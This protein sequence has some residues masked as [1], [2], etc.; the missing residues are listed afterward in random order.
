MR[1]NRGKAIRKHLRFYR[2]VYGLE[3]PYHVIL[4]GNFI[5]AALKYKIDIADRL[6]VQLQVPGGD[7]VRLYITKSSLEE[8][9]AVPG[10]KGAN[11]VAWASKMCE[12]LDDTNCK[13]V[14]NDAPSSRLIE[15][16]W[17]V[18][19]AWV[20]GP[21]KSKLSQ[22]SGAEGAKKTDDNDLATRR[23][24][25]ATQDQGLRRALATI[26]GV[27][28][29]YLNNVALVVE[30][31]SDVS[32]SFNAALEN[33]K[34]SA[35]TDVESALLESVAKKRRRD[36]GDVA[37]SNIV[38]V[39]GAAATDSGPP[40]TAASK[41]DHIDKKQRVKHRAKAANPLSSREPTKGSSNQKKS[42]A[43]KYK[44]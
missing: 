29:V 40:S 38:G 13:Q 23:F 39:G 43:A 30:T 34:I 17:R 2:I 42:K 8:L 31:P 22:A 18:H 16:L 26:P 19:R 33:S 3:S 9:R 36:G 5:F 20:K 44:K 11:S 14:E 4:D 6:K 7:A 28:L 24:I 37:G 25:V 12:V 21:P 27:P 32:R 15:Y 35:V 41:E 10:G 1:I